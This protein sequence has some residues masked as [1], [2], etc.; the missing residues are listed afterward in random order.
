MHV[1]RVFGGDGWPE[2]AYSVGLFQ[3]FEQPEVIILGLLAEIAH[4]L[5]N[6]IADLNRRELRFQLGDS[7][8]ELLD[9]YQ[10]TFRPVSPPQVQ[11]HLGWA[12]WFYD[13]EP[14]PAVQMVYPDRAGRWPWDPE[15]SE[16]FRSN[17]PMLESAPLPAWARVSS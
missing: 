12:N 9:G 16:G 4:A 17:Q 8:D 6:D 2:F 3:S 14:Y 10:V 15:A 5:L 7:T 1:L 13:F 11:A